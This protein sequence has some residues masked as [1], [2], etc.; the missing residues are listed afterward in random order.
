MLVVLQKGS[1]AARQ[2][3]VGLA[4]DKAAGVG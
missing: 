2:Q 3:G 4:V 1:K